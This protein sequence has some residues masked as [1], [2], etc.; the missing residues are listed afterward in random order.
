MNFKDVKA[1][2]WAK[3]YIDSLVA[4]NMMGGYPDGTFKPEQAITRAKLLLINKAINRT[5][6]KAA[7]DANP[8][9]EKIPEP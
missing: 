4:N 7:I 9:N 6:D 3:Q 1:N 2:H 5:P 8:K